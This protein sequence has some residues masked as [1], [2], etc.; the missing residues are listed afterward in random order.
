MK[1][2]L[3]LFIPVILIFAGCSQSI[4][5]PTSPES[6]IQ[7]SVISLPPSSSLQTENEL[8]SVSD[9]ID[10]TKGGI[11]NMNESYYSESGRVS[12]RA[13]LKISKDS[14]TGNETIGYDVYSEDGSIVFSPGMAFDKD[15][16]FDIKF[17]G[18][19]LSNIENPDEI[20]FL[21]VDSEENT[22]PVQ[23]SSLNVD[24]EKGILEVK[25]ALIS[26]FSRY[27]WAR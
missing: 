19:D 18:L 4:L 23:Y 17:T 16:V 14:F 2:I 5:E 22:Y 13:K 25:G 27:I 21:Y 20:Q 3:L 26:H 11:V 10:G 7:K 24:I 6:S 8:F 12:I 15:L 9:D 1:K